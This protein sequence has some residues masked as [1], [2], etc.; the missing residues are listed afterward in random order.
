MPT[1]AQIRARNTHVN[2]GQGS[3]SEYV[4]G[5]LE[6]FYRDQLGPDI[7][8]DA[9]R[10]CPKGRT[11]DLAESIES[12]IDENGDLIV[13]ATGSGERWY[14]AFVELGHYI[15]HPSTGDVGPERQP[16]QPFLR[17]ALY[18]TRHYY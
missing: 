2:V 18:Q 5:K 4:K 16:A 12:H 14:A 7:A 15:Y 3:F 11:G 10:Y 17:P 1:P 8:G 9:K 13:G 6:D